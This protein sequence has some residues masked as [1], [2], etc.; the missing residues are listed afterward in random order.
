MIIE[1]NFF[2]FRY[3][4]QKLP[5]YCNNN[6]DWFWININVLEEDYFKAR[7][8]A[9]KWLEADGHNCYKYTEWVGF[10][11]QGTGYILSDE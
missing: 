7:N 10:E 11:A 8:K 3:K 4:V 5:E 1:K 6:N 9:E 2:R